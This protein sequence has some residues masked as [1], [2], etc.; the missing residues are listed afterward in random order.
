MTRILTSRW[1]RLAWMALGGGIALVVLL[2]ISED[3]YI[4]FHSLIETFSIIVAGSIFMIAWNTRE[5]LDNNYFLFIGIAYF[6]T[7]ILDWLHMLAYHGMGVFAVTGSNLATQLWVA[8]RYLQSITLLLA[9]FFCSRKLKVQFQ[10]LAYGVVTSLLLA[11]IFYWHNFP[12][13]YIED[14][15]LTPFKLASEHIVIT[16]LGA[17]VFL[18]L[19]QRRWFDR[20]VL[21]LMVGSMVAAIAAEFAFTAYVN[22]Y[23]STSAIGHF[24]RLVSFYLAYKAVIE[25]GLVKPQA[26]LFRNLSR[27]EERLRL[28]AEELQSRNEELDTFAHTVAHDL[29]NPLSTI[30][31]IVDTLSNLNIKPRDWSEFA[32]DLKATAYDMD[33]IIDDLLLFAEIRKNNLSLDEVNMTAV[34]AKVTRRLRQL[35]EQS[36]AKIIVPKRWPVALGYEPWVEEVLAN[37][38]SNAIKYGGRPPIIHLGSDMEPNGVLRFWVQDNGRGISPEDQKNLFKPFSQL[39][40]RSLGHG[41]GL[42]I[43]RHI[44]EKLGGRVGVESALGQGSCFYFTLNQ[45]PDLPPEKDEDELQLLAT[46]DV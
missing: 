36:Q 14:S 31:V 11:S 40:H 13:C 17:A 46:T 19:Q 1:T 38:I 41:L 5:H 37:Y 9:P 20:E 26:V 3:S 22:V 45:L 39:H 30:I 33:R 16:I 21:Y 4:L 15:G 12:V 23:G 35:I 25:T 10:I 32:Q 29:K 42:S 24:L 7:S 18:L 44:I 34:V 8:G 6:F 27:S 28:Q 43:V 2:A